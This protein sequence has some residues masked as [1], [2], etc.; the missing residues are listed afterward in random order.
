VNPT[1][2]ERTKRAAAAL[3]SAL[4]AEGMAVRGPDALDTTVVI[5]GVTAIKITVGKKP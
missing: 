5:G 1:A 3:V 4:K 2:D